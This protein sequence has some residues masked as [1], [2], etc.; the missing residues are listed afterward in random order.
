MSP[1][2]GFRAKQTKL[3]RIEALRWTTANEGGV[4]PMAAL[5]A[6]N[7]ENL[8]AVSVTLVFKGKSR[9]IRL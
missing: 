9:I 2:F 8:R 4:K 3:D 5:G 6:A 1:F 7:T